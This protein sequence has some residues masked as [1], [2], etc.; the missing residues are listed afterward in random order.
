MMRRVVVVMRR[1]VGLGRRRLGCRRAHGERAE[2]MMG[3]GRRVHGEER[4][5]LAWEGGA[6]QAR[7]ACTSILAWA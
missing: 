5:T 2:E 7:K 4:R 3:S 6:H 1:E